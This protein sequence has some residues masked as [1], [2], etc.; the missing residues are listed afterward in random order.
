MDIEH[1]QEMT[2]KFRS[3]GYDA[4]YVTSET[5]VKERAQILDDFRQGKFSI[6]VNCG[7]YTEGT[8]IPNIDCVVLA[9]PTK[10]RNLLVQMIGRGMR[11]FPGKEDCHVIDMIGSVTKGIVT[12]PTL[13]GLD[14]DDVVHRVSPEKMKDMAEEKKLEEEAAEEA[15]AKERMMP[16]QR[17]VT[18]THYESIQD[19]V[20]DS[21]IDEWI[22]QVSQFSWVG[23]GYGKY[24]LS[25]SNRGFL[26]LEQANED[27]MSLY[28]SSPLPKIYCFSAQI[29]RKRYQF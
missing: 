6:L 28:I 13:Y 25:L 16:V 1:V 8:D 18:F 29:E 5:H 26:R 23:V 12:T 19:L 4:R 10:S 21:R 24:I 11:L 7:I 9:R 20:N 15:A 17:N 2:N 14:P 3:F 22:R 27:G